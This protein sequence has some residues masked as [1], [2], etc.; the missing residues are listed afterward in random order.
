M[1]M[2]YLCSLYD[3]KKY[4]K[5]I[6]KCLDLKFFIIYRFNLKWMFEDYNL[7]NILIVYIEIL[8]NIMI[9]W[10]I[11]DKNIMFFHW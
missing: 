4:H 11:M 10:S 3:M 7:L 6:S 9:N 8:K 1:N 5:N 2:N